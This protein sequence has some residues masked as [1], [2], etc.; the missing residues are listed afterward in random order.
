MEKTKNKVVAPRYF[1][2]SLM[3]MLGVLGFYLGG[4]WVWLGTAA[5][6]CL[7]VLDVS[8][9]RDEQLHDVRATGLQH[10]VLY[11]QLPL[12]VMLWLMFADML[13]TSSGSVLEIMGGIF[14][15]SFLTA[16]G[17]LPPAHELMHRHGTLDRFYCTLYLTV[18]LLPMNDLGHVKGHHLKVATSE[19]SDTP[20]RGESVYTFAFRSLWGQMKDSIEIE[21]GRLKKTKTSFWSPQSRFFQSVI[22]MSTWLIIWF[23]IAGIQALPLYILTMVIFYLVLGGFNYTQ[24]YGLI[25]V[26]GEP[27]ETR[28]SWNQL[29]PLSRALSFEISNHSEHHLK[30]T[31]FYTDLNP[32]PDAPQLPSIALCFV[33]AFIPPLWEKKIV[34]P[35]LAIWDETVASEAERKLA[36]EANIKAGWV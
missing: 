31:R 11:C 30:P 35:Q 14:S 2:G 13:S 23:S 9:P 34:R 32:Y 8:L 26:I 25:R 22:L 28:H 7:V 29:K 6:I 18:F 5:F 10:F 1:S 27:I 33:C 17:G 4:L 16:L 21:K 3:L 20:R 36:H 24:H 15:L 19:D 12:I